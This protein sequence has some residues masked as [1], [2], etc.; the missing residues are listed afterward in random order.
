[1]E[2]TIKEAWTKLVVEAMED[3][4]TRTVL[5]DKVTRTLSDLMDKIPGAFDDL[6]SAFME[7]IMSPY[8]GYAPADGEEQR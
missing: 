8:A 6:T 1:M 2:S 3:D 7:S 5:K 4:E